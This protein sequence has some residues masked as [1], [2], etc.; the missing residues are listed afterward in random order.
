MNGRLALSFAVAALIVGVGGLFVVWHRLGKIEGRLAKEEAPR[1]RPP[2]V[3]PPSPAQGDPKA[4]AEDPLESRDPLV[5]LDYLV[6]SAG[7]ASDN[8]YQ[9]YTD[10]SGDLHQIKREISQQKSKL[11]SVVP[12]EKPGIIGRL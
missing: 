3:F 1:G 5:K 10:V 2:G 9:Y 12:V 11:Q 8:A 6:K 4:D 7:E